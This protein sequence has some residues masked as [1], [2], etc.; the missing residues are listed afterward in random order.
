M[1]CAVE[2]SQCIQL[3]RER[4]KMFSSQP[5]Y[6]AD[7]KCYNKCMVCVCL[8]TLSAGIPAE[9]KCSHK[10][11]QKSEQK[12][13]RSV[14]FVRY[15]PFAVLLIFVFAIDAPNEWSHEIDM[16]LNYEN[17]NYNSASQN[18]HWRE[19]IVK[20][21]YRQKFIVN[22]LPKILFISIP[23]FWTEGW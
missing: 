1:D 13:I 2:H 4:E 17:S 9:G 6:F 14:W 22:S 12:L 19:H 16:R 8:A 18:G 20:I 11:P 10:I 21:H 3:E 23:R 7:N 15:L 5:A